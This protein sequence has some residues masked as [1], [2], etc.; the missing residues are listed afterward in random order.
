MAMLNLL[1]T[2]IIPDIRVQKNIIGLSLST[3]IRVFPGNLLFFTHCPKGTASPF[4]DF[5]SPDQLGSI[6]RLSCVLLH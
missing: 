1:H 3:W 5:A 4:Y 2:L 6:T